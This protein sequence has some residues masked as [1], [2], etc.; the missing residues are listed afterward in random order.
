M[1]HK[2]L[3]TY[4][5]ILSLDENHVAGLI[6]VINSIII[7]TPNTNNIRFNIL[8]Y[9]N[10]DIFIDMF[11]CKFG[12]NIIFRIEEFI[13]YPQYIEF[14]NKNVHIIDTTGKFGYIAN[15]MNFARFY[16]PSIFPDISIGLYLDSDV[17]V[18]TDIT[19]IFN[20]PALPNNLNDID[21]A[22][23]LNRSIECMNIHPKFNMTGNG[24]NTG[25]YIL[26]FD[27]WRQ[28]DLTQKC[29]ELMLDHKKGN[30]FK[31][32]TQPI[33]NI[34]YYGKCIDIDKRWNLT[35]LGSNEYDANKLAKSYILH[36]TGEKKPW[37]K[38]GLNKSIWE[39]YVI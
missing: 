24:F 23:P 5:I 37:M 2:L 3:M 39:K 14:L 31:L 4:D 12:Q 36:W 25:V 35:G 34:L 33:I 19:K 18:Q 20:D 30:L 28:N 13:N 11:K 1:L 6:T 38:N 17:I 21:I 22:S 26:N 8:V 32:G 15:T 7:N 27:K 9:N 16:L 29:E 10:R